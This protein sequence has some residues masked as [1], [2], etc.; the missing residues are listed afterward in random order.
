MIHITI[1]RDRDGGYRA[2]IYFDGKLVWWT[3]G[4]ESKSSAEKA[5]QIAKQTND[6]V[7]VL[8]QT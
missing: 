1:R 3:R 7:T 4:Y 2:R 8:D 6:L 5:I